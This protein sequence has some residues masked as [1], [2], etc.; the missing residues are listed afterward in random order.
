M[1]FAGAESCGKLRSSDP[2]YIGCV[3]GW[4][5]ALAEQMKGLYYMDGGPI[6]L[7]QVRNTLAMLSDS[8]HLMGKIYIKTIGLPR[9]A[10]DRDEKE[11][12]LRA[13]GRCLR[14]EGGQ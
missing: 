12:K 4:Y 5:T 10:R 11:K 7:V 3:K 14:S 8:Y 1:F 6:T 2:L 9:Q 13:N